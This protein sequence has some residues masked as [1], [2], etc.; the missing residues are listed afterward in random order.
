VAV[1]TLAP[2][3]P[4]TAPVQ[5]PTLFMRPVTPPMQM[6]PFGPGGMERFGRD[7]ERRMM[8]R[9]MPMPQPSQAPVLPAGPAPPEKILSEAPLFVSM[10]VD[11]I[12]LKA[13]APPKA[14]EGPAGPSRAARPRPAEH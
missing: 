13:P 6:N 7:R 11:V 1:E 14:P 2:P 10:F 9:L 12:K 5:A 3:P 4:V 8:P